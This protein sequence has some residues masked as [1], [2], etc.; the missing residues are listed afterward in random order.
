MALRTY[1]RR[2]LLVS[3]GLVLVMFNGWSRRLRRK[4]NQPI[5]KMEDGGRHGENQN[6][7]KRKSVLRVTQTNQNKQ[8]VSRD[9]STENNYE[10]DQRK[11]T[12]DTKQQQ[13]VTAH[14]SMNSLNG[15][16]DLENGER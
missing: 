9:W 1:A 5:N 4:A 13:L 8:K 3:D 7:R 14:T 12:K 2:V 10:K 16:G 11:K 15:D 6:D